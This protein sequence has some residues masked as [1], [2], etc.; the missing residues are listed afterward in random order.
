[1]NNGFVYMPCSSYMILMFLQ[2]HRSAARFVRDHRRPCHRLHVE[3][4]VDTQPPLQRKLSSYHQNSPFSICLESS[5]SPLVNAPRSPRLIFTWNPTRILHS[6]LSTKQLAAL[7]STA[8]AHLI[9][10]QVP[11]RHP[12]LPSATKFL[13]FLH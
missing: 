6:Q 5:F 2:V 4:C 10:N 11:L 8:T 13:Y 9:P 3:C 12:I 1:M 7:I